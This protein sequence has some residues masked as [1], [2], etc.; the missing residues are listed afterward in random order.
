[1]GKAGRMMERHF[2]TLDDVLENV[3]Y[4][5]S[6]ARNV[7]G[8]QAERASPLFLDCAIRLVSVI[9]DDERDE[10]PGILRALGAEI[11]SRRDLLSLDA[12]AYVESLDELIKIIARDMLE[13]SGLP[14]Y[15]KTPPAD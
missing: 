13:R 10:T 15:N 3:I 4:L 6:T 8:W 11:A 7:V 5:I 1:M 14:P 2:L 9:L 12:T